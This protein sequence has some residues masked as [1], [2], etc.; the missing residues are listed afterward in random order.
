M[1][2]IEYVM[3]QRPQDRIADN[4]L[5]LAS[6]VHV[7]RPPE[8]NRLRHYWIINLSSSRTPKESSLLVPSAP[9]IADPIIT[10]VFINIL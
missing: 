5:Y 7:R 9:T 10:G 2:L 1:L 3:R 4:Y 8:S 6:V